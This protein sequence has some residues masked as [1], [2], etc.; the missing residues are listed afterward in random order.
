MAISNEIGRDKPVSA[1]AN[2]VTITVS[3]VAQLPSVEDA[4]K[5]YQVM[6]GATVNKEKSISLQLGIWSGRTITSSVM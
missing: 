3:D 1:Y 4:I 6:A 5:G 2:D